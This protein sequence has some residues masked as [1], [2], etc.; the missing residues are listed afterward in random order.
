VCKYYYFR[1]IFIL[2]GVLP[3]MKQTHSMEIEMPDFMKLVD[4][5]ERKKIIEE[6]EDKIK[7]HVSEMFSHTA[8]EI[9]AKKLNLHITQKK[10]EHEVTLE[11]HKPKLE[12]HET[13]LEVK[14]ALAEKLLSL[15][16][17]EAMQTL[18]MSLAEGNIDESGYNELKSLIQP[19]ASKTAASVGTTLSNRCPKCGKEVEPTANFCR[20]CGATL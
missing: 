2:A 3:T 4:A 9:I 13:D 10:E 8:Q 6:V 14:T 1:K 18:K 15:S 12:K 17:E 7:G 16:P 5:E 20:F 19:I 11:E